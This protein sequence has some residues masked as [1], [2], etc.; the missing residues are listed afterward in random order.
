MSR[1]NSGVSRGVKITLNV[2]A[3]TPIT[4]RPAVQEDS[5]LAG[6][7]IPETSIHSVRMAEFCILQD[8]NPALDP[9]TSNELETG[10]SR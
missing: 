4:V 7:N 5:V 2:P 6:L 10:K 8:F 1:L 3:A 9:K